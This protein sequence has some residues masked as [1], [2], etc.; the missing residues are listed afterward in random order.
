MVPIPKAKRWLIMSAGA[1]VALCASAVVGVTLSGAL[2]GDRAGHV[3]AHQTAQLS[4]TPPPGPLTPAEAANAPTAT[5]T[6][7]PTTSSAPIA[8]ATD[9]ISRLLSS[10][11]VTGVTRTSAV[12][13]TWSAY[14]AAAAE[15]VHQSAS[16]QVAP[17]DPVWIAV[18]SGKYVPEFGNGESFSWGAIIYDAASGAPLSSI[19]GPG[20]W[21]SWLASLPPITSSGS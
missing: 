13:T 18:A 8:N 21:P 14:V 16:L 12:E 1:G 17:N 20:G 6:V 9:A 2:A 11:E 5:G 15:G 4:T 10:G 19:A 3:S 7:V